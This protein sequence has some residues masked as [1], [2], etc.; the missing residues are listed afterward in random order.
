PVR[1]RQ[2]LVGL[3][4]R[5]HRHDAGDAHLSQALQPVNILAEAERGDFDGI[6]ITAGLLRHLAKFR[7]DLAD[8]AAGGWNPAI[9]IADRP[10]R[11]IWESAPTWIGG[12]GF[13]TGLG[14]AIIGSK[15]TNSP[16]YSAF[17]F[18]QI[19]FIASI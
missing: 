4:G 2:H 17:S 3:L 15:L 13:C 16:W 10:P 11:A 12:C 14:L 7:Q 5:E 9:P 19:A 1:D 8:V 18:V 6:R